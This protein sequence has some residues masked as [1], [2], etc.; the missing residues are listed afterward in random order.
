MID[1][2]ALM[3]LAWLSAPTGAFAVPWDR[4]CSQGTTI[5][6]A[7]PW[8]DG[9]GTAPRRPARGRSAEPKNVIYVTF[10]WGLADAH[11]QSRTL[12]VVYGHNPSLLAS[13]LR[14]HSAVRACTVD[15]EPSRVAEGAGLNAQ[16]HRQT[17][18]TIT[19]PA[20]NQETAH[21]P[22]GHVP[23]PACAIGR[24]W[25]LYRFLRMQDKQGPIHT[26]QQS[27]PLPA[28]VH[29]KDSARNPPLPG[30]TGR[31]ITMDER[32]C[33]SVR[34]AEPD[35]QCCTVVMLGA[36]EVRSCRERD[37]LTITDV[38]ARSRHQPPDALRIADEG[39]GAQDASRFR[40]AACVSAAPNISTGCLPVYLSSHDHR[41]TRSNL[42]VF[43]R[44]GGP[45][46]FRNRR[47]LSCR[48][49]LGMKRSHLTPRAGRSGLSSS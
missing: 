22:A 26:D 40:A 25:A 31:R 15:A 45:I 49:V 20:R 1:A 39:P 7:P 37:K 19:V 10:R 28:P 43:L 44:Q 27:G 17:Q 35:D 32:L 42:H 38:C 21:H 6:M 5:L 47:R 4:A 48:K 30:S 14:L 33:R 36:D 24:V 3:A 9:S 2:S 13:F 16:W 34:R 41:Y 29:D 23:P 12:T 8:D 46:S 11:G 18:I